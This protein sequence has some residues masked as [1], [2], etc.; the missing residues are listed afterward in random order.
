[1]RAIK[2]CL[3][4]VCACG[5]AGLTSVA[6]F[7]ENPQFLKLGGGSPTFPIKTTSKTAVGEKP[8]LETAD[9]KLTCES[10]ATTTP[11]EITS[12]T[13]GVS[14]IEFKGCVLSTNGEN[15]TT[16]GDT[17]GIILFGTTSLHLVAYKTSTEL[18]A[19]MLFLNINLE[20][21][22]GSVKLKLIGNFI[23]LL[24]PLNVDATSFTL[25]FDHTGFI[26]K[27]T[28]CE[29]PV[30]VCLPGGKTALYSL[31][32]NAGLGLEHAVLIVKQSI[33]TAT[34]LLIDA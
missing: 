15:C 9:G 11:S 18:L 7:A 33:T 22:C 8:I 14:G 19:G 25:L 12:L 26:Q 4:L 27:P 2:A 29:V 30:A 16:S 6:A 24:G 17:V 23:G 21:S 28:S 3:V 10:D 13:L 32:I 31:L 20:F 1:M 34:D 5:I